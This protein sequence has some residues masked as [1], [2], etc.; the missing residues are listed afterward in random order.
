MVHR[1]THSLLALAGLSPHSL[2]QNYVSDGN[3]SLF[4]SALPEIVIVT[5]SGMK[6]EENSAECRTPCKLD[7]RLLVG[8]YFTSINGRVVFHLHLN[9]FEAIHKD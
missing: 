2:H 6:T 3:T 8:D 9:D 1:P 7:F 5:H 4:G